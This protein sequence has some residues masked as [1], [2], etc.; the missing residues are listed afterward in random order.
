MHPERT[1]GMRILF[2]EKGMI[3][4]SNHSSSITVTLFRP[5]IFI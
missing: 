1:F 2:E 4:V 3:N 5:G